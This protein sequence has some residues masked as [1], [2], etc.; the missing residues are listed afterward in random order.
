LYA[1]L[2][3][4]GLLHIVL[5]GGVRN[6]VVKA[7]ILP[8]K[9]GQN[10]ARFSVPSTAAESGITYPNPS[11]A[12]NSE[13]DSAGSP[14]GGDHEHYE[15]SSQVETD[16]TRDG[17][18]HF[19][20]A[21]KNLEDIMKDLESGSHDEDKSGDDDRDD[22]NDDSDEAVVTKPSPVFGAL[23]YTGTDTKANARSSTL[24]ARDRAIILDSWRTVIVDPVKVPLSTLSALEG[25]ETESARQQNTRRFYEQLVDQ[26]NNPLG[27]HNSKK[28]LNSETAL[29][30]KGKVALA[31][32]PVEPSL[33]RDIQLTRGVVLKCPT[34]TAL[35]CALIARAVAHSVRA[36]FVTLSKQTL[37]VVRRMCQLSGVRE[38]YVSSAHLLSVLLDSVEQTA[39]GT[40][41]QSQPLIV[42]IASDMRAV[43]DS[44]AM[45]G[46]IDYEL[47]DRRSRVVFMFSDPDETLEPGHTDLPKRKAALEREEQQSRVANTEAPE[48]DFPFPSNLFGAFGG[49]PSSNDGTTNT[50]N[51]SPDQNAQQQQSQNAAR[52]M[53]RSYNVV[54][55]NGTV[56]VTSLPNPFNQQTPIGR[57][58]MPFPLREDP[59]NPSPFLFSN[60][61]K[62][63]ESPHASVL[64]SNL[65]MRKDFFA[66]LLQQARSN[67]FSSIFNSSNT[68]G[69]FGFMD[70]FASPQFLQS[71]VQMAVNQLPPHALDGTGI[72]GRKV[73]EVKVHMMPMI[74]GQLPPSL[75]SS[76]LQNA[77]LTSSEHHNAD[78]KQ[79]YYSQLRELEQLLAKLKDDNDQFARDNGNMVDSFRRMLFE[80]LKKPP[81]ASDDN[82]NDRLD[83]PEHEEPSNDVSAEQMRRRIEILEEERRVGHILAARLQESMQSK[84]RGEVRR[85]MM[86]EVDEFLKRAKT[87]QELWKQGKDQQESVDDSPGSDSRQAEASTDAIVLPSRASEHFK[88]NK[89]IETIEID[90]PKDLRLRDRW[91]ALAEEEIWDMIA[92]LNRQMLI[93]KLEWMQLEVQPS[94]GGDQ[95]NAS[96]INDSAR[97]RQSPPRVDCKLQ[98]SCH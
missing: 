77:A 45:H 43:V 4:L 64:T 91:T 3:V 20:V 42:H 98:S 68:G 81:S 60:P 32:N 38:E 22:T 44:V 55:F 41:L 17:Q 93:R 69:I 58:V 7:K 27:G 25:N 2:V 11:D 86:R 78:E 21:F 56:T 79:H 8:S 71:V 14:S 57:I 85:D 63:K 40:S 46:L 62:A 87:R 15:I 75:Q 35:M 96:D 12:S 82:N 92:N 13:R 16:A 83:D 28:W 36:N 34:G 94:N 74:P 89:Y 50:G 51:G 53:Q 37:S 49:P 70:P 72:G 9:F 5:G 61:Q 47:A 39:E 30:L 48:P 65:S 84:L 33:A 88:N 73:V 31:C 59:D 97:S 24:S 90:P 52:A 67:Q 1:I 54:F 19:S 6:G 18:P 26:L 29:L 80:R 10:I 95:K 66:K 23:R 76:L